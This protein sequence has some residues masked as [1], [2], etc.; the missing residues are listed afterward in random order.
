MF[1]HTTVKP[2]T[3]YEYLT[4]IFDFKLHFFPILYSFK[5]AIYPK[6]TPDRITGKVINPLCMKTNSNPGNADRKNQ[7]AHWPSQ[8]GS[9]CQGMVM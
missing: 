8:M 6:E 2:D 5:E 1:H 7:Q 9:E 4:L 3:E